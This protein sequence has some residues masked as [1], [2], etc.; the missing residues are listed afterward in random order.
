MTG[1]DVA[2]GVTW[3]AFV[4]VVAVAVKQDQLLRQSVASMRKAGEAIEALAEAN[5]VICH[6]GAVEAA[7]GHTWRQAAIVVMAE[8][9][10]EVLAR[11]RMAEAEFR[12][13]Q[14]AA[15]IASRPA[16]RPESRAQA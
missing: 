6:R 8:H 12:A 4:C 16:S 10:P 13:K 14:E 5:T 2:F 11:L 15:F 9:A 7:V 3:L 1:L